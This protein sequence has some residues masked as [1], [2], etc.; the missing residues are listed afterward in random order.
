MGRRLLADET[1]GI[2]HSS[3]RLFKNTLNGRLFS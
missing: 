2:L 3:F 1:W